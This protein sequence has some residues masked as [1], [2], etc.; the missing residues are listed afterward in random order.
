MKKVWLIAALALSVIVGGCGGNGGSN[1]GKS[2]GASSTGDD[3]GNKESQP[4]EVR[5]MS[6]FFGATP[7]SKDNPVELE[8]E[9]ATNAKLNIEW[10]AAQNY[11]DKL[12][13]VLASGDFPDLI[14]I[15]AVNPIQNAVFARAAEQGAFWDVSPYID[16]Y[17]NLKGKI[18]QTAWDLT[19]INGGNYVIPRPR[20][21]EGET[22]F[23][24]RKDWLDNVGLE[25]P[26][27]A[28][29]L[30]AVMKAFF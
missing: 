22:F 16:E 4:V 17:P 6:H 5:V 24:L 20:P 2:A 21:S 12:N 3:S 14:L 29:E 9:K 18:T 13:V 30:Y 26:T 25:M 27:T 23:V 8:I 15:P 28:E 1:A 11:Q 10:N 7:P 19:K